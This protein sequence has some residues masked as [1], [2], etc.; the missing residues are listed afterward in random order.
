MPPFPASTRGLTRMMAHAGTH[1]GQ[2]VGLCDD[3]SRFEVLMFGDEGYV[4][5]H[6]RIQ[7][8]NVL[9]GGG[10]E[11]AA[12]G[13]RASFILDVRFVFVSEVS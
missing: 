13:C 2:R 5:R 6:I 12:H 1:I 11:L 10:D 4:C 7:G 9:A 3:L 8:A